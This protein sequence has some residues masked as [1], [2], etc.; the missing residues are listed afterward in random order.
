MTHLATTFITLNEVQQYA[1]YGVCLLAG[2]GVVYGLV[3]FFETEGADVSGVDRRLDHFHR[4]RCWSVLGIPAFG[5]GPRSRSCG[6]RA[7]KS[8]LTTAP[9]T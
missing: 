8:A 3:R 5:T 2:V 4:G 6:T 9:R 7:S 1:L